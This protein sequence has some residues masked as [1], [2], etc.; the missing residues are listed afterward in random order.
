MRSPMIVY[1]CDVCGRVFMRDADEVD[2]LPPDWEEITAPDHS[3]YL[4][5]PQCSVAAGQLFDNMLK[6]RHG[7]GLQYAGLQEVQK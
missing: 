4:M 6:E 2:M 5:C 3:I 1:T 7:T